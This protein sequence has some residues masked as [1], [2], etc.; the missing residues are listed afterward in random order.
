MYCEKWL[1]IGYGIMSVTLCAFA[2]VVSVMD[3]YTTS[4]YRQFR[5][6]VFVL[7]GVSGA[8][9]IVHMVNTDDVTSTVFT[10]H[11]PTSRHDPLP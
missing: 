8:V 9:P 2:F 3:K 10:V 7:V 6:L 11:P 4:Q 1:S 5:A